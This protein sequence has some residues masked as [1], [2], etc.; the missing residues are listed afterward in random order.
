MMNVVPPS[1]EMADTEPDEKS[2]AVT[3]DHEIPSTER[4]AVRG[5]AL[6][7][8]K[9]H[10]PTATDT[11]PAQATSCP[12][13]APGLESNGDDLAVQDDPSGDVMMQ[14]CGLA[15]VES[16]PPAMNTGQPTVM[17]LI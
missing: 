17:A 12:W 4:T 8:G 6:R 7:E 10:T 11:P 9:I 16:L 3:A 5:V 2:T 15:L 14:R 13:W 1:V